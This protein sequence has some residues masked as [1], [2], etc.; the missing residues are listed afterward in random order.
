MSVAHNAI[1]EQ[2]QQ[3]IHMIDALTG[4]RQMYRLVLTNMVLTTPRVN[5]TDDNHL[6]KCVWNIDI[7]IQNFMFLHNCNAVSRHA[8]STY[9]FDN[10]THARCLSIILVTEFC[11]DSMTWVYVALQ[12]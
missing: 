5:I 7:Q 12:Y 8:S 1:A 4:P 2:L 3:L 9:C 10:T 11:S 6:L